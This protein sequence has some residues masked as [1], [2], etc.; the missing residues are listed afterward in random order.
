M[1]SNNIL[2][3]F[4]EVHEFKI[5]E[6]KHV[7][8]I[9]SKTNLNIDEFQKII[10]QISDKQLPNNFQI[11][12]IYSLID[13]I[14]QLNDFENINVIYSFMKLNRNHIYSIII[15]Y[16][17]NN[18]DFSENELIEFKINNSNDEYLIPYKEF[19][20]IGSRDLSITPY[21]INLARSDCQSK[22]HVDKN[23]PMKLSGFIIENF[24]I[25]PIPIELTCSINNNQIKCF[26][27]KILNNSSGS[28]GSSNNYM[29][30]NSNHTKLPG[31]ILEKSIEDKNKY[32][33]DD[34]EFILYITPLSNTSIRS[35][36]IP[37]IICL[38]I[39][40]LIIIIIIII[41]IILIKKPKDKKQSF[42]YKLNGNK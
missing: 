33:L 38:S 19:D 30:F 29:E 32:K 3:V 16:L 41:V 24:T 20:L 17:R 42:L 1:Q 37:L 6:N 7:K 4:N 31:I 5:I 10:N 15:D 23:K 27:A 28:S 35:I 36:R 14:K 21:S 18:Y 2:I 11:N 12:N 9:I 40:L 13:E 22:I 39:L 26:H 34:I 25:Q 8:I